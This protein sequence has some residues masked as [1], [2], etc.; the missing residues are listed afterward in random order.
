[1]EIGKMVSNMVR[2]HTLMQMAELNEAYGM[3][4]QGLNSLYDNK[5]TNI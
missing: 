5:R 4:D 3:K 2:V 1:M